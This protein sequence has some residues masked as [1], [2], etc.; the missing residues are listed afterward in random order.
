MFPSFY[1]WERGANQTGI[2][3]VRP[4]FWEFPDDPMCANDVD[5][6][7]LGDQLLVSPIVEKGQLHA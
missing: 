1:S 2:G 6:W 5:A 3:I 4:L 7:M